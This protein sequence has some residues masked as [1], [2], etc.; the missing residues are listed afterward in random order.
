MTKFRNY[1]K[2]FLPAGIGIVLCAF[3][4]YRVLNPEGVQTGTFTALDT[5]F[6]VSIHGC[7]PA[8]AEKIFA[9]MR[10]CARDMEKKYSVHI[11]DSL[12]SRINGGAGKDP[13]E[14]DDETGK[15][16]LRSLEIEKASGGLFTPAILP[17]TSLWDMSTKGDCREHSPSESAFLLPQEDQIA[18]A[19]ELSGRNLVK[20]VET[21][22]GGLAVELAP[23]S[24]IDLGGI[25]KGRVIDACAA[26]LGRGGLAGIVNAGGDMTL[27]GR[28][29]EGNWRIG[30]KN[31]RGP[32]LSAVIELA[33]GSVATS[34]DYERF[35]DIQGR[36]Y[37]HIIDPATGW[38]A[39][40]LASVTAAAPD[41]VTADAAATAAFVAGPSKAVETGLA[42]GAWWILAIDSS[43]NPQSGGERV[44]L[45]WKGRP[46]K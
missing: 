46:L 31:P 13:V 18:K 4:I 44:R 45:D 9:A 33:E 12:I 19:R 16:L 3:W 30:V 24:G 28:K 40:G 6:E 17:L 32:G 38:P 35:F 26:L 43:G 34:G 23:G 20:V 5:F 39:G 25:A 2:F 41:A 21:P 11:E 37:H 14:V 22:T 1:R 29:N 8:E 42:C 36:R 7:D 10:D 27:V 15:L